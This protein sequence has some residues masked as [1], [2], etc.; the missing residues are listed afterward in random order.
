[1]KNVINI[2]VK[3]INEKFL[4]YIEKAEKK[5]WNECCFKENILYYFGRRDN[6]DSTMAD[7]ISNYVLRWLG[8]A[9]VIDDH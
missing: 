1:M 3:I 6:V 9:E 7:F 8:M 4:P 5:I 2:V